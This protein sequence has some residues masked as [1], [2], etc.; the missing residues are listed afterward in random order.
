MEVNIPK[1]LEQCVGLEYVILRNSYDLDKYPIGGDIDILTKDTSGIIN[2]LMIELNNYIFNG[3]TVEKSIPDTHT[4]LDLLKDGTLIVRF[5]IIDTL[6]L[7]STVLVD[8]LLSTKLNKNDIMFTDDVGDI[9]TRLLE[10]FNNPHKNKHLDFV[11]NKY[12]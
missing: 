10:Y 4:H 8:Y 2:A 3:Y 6:T 7:N 12:I 9:F 1:I 11:K 5:D